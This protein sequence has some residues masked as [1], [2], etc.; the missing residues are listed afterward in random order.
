MFKFFVV[1]ADQDTVTHTGRGFTWGC[2]EETPSLK[3]RKLLKSMQISQNMSVYLIQKQNFQT[4]KKKEKF[5]VQHLQ[6]IKLKFWIA[7]I[8]I[9]IKEFTKIWFYEKEKKEAIRSKMLVLLQRLK[10]RSQIFTWSTIM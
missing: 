3:D 2:V 9:T 4:H 5:P 10:L 7:K 6:T 1:L 8:I